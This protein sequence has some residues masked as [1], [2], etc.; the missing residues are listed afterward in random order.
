MLKS[1]FSATSKRII[2]SGLKKVRIK[3]EVNSDKKYRIVNLEVLNEN[4]FIDRLYG[5]DDLRTVINSGNSIDNL[6]DEW[7]PFNNQ[8]YLLLMKESLAWHYQ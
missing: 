8:E 3:E 4:N 2:V 5:S 1:V 7:K 6:I